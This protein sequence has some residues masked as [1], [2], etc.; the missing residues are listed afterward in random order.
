MD[1][2]ID[3]RENFLSEV[4]VGDLVELVIDGKFFGRTDNLNERYGGV[5]CGI[6]KQ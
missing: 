1:E 6:N 3:K 2:G 4:G 5:C